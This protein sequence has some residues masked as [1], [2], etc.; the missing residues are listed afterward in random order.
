MKHRFFAILGAALA[1]FCMAAGFAGCKPDEQENPGQI[2]D[3]NAHEHVWGNSWI[4]GPETHW[5]ECEICHEKYAESRHFFQ[6]V[7]GGSC[8]VYAAENA[9]R[10]M[11]HLSSPEGETRELYVKEVWAHIGEKTPGKL[12][13]A[14]STGTGGT[15]VNNVEISAAEGGW[16]KAV[17]PG[18]GLRLLT[19]SF[20]RLQAVTMNIAVDEIVFIA[21]DAKGQGEQVL[22]APEIAEA[23]GTRLS[24]Q[25]RL[26][27]SQQFPGEKRECYTC[28]YPEPKTEG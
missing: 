25:K 10:P 9:D 18:D 1:A 12:R 6:D 8:T 15:F 14:Y 17:F 24:N 2:V 21:N 22:L 13:V 28:R 4:Q 23:S 27:D 26:I 20:I 7:T 11:L 3:P 16:Q 19:Y 5:R